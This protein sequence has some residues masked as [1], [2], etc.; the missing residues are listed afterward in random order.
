MIVKDLFKVKGIRA[1]IYTLTISLSLSLVYYTYIFTQV[2]SPFEIIQLLS[3]LIITIHWWWGA[4]FYFYYFYFPT[5]K[6][7]YFLDFLI[8]LFL[9]LAIVYYKVFFLWALFM[10]LSYLVAYIMYQKKPNSPNFDERVERFAKRKALLD[11]V[12]LILLTTGFLLGLINVLFF[13][14]YFIDIFEIVTTFVIIIFS[15]IYIFAS[16]FYRLR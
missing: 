6:Y 16:H 5:E 12:V 10:S 8:I 7:F 15:H 13:N 11:L 3:T 14:Y 9:L 1:H 2:S 4:S